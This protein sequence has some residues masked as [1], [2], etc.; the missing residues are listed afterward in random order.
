MP[1]TKEEVA[2][3][4]YDFKVF[5]SKSDTKGWKYYNLVQDTET[6][7]N[8]YNS[9]RLFYGNGGG[10]CYVVSVGTYRQNKPVSAGDLLKGL[11]VIAE[12]VGPTMLV[13]PDAILLPPTDPNGTPWVSADFKAVVQE[14]LKQSA[15]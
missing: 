13:I 10:N 6:H 15:K 12:Q 14:M 11:D 1:A 8:L 9:M 2:A 3:S 5:D 4:Q 7:Y